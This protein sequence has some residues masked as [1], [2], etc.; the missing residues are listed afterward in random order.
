MTLSYTLSRKFFLDVHKI[1]QKQKLQKSNSDNSSPVHLHTIQESMSLDTSRLKVLFSA[2]A[3]AS[4]LANKAKEVLA[5]TSLTFFLLAVIFFLL[6]KKCIKRE[7]RKII[8]A[9]SQMRREKRI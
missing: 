6:Y 4:K 5:I 3:V 1:K 2:S 8:K 7:A 9:R